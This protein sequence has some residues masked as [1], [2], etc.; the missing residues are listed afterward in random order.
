MGDK[1]MKG[2]KQ[3][4][5]KARVSKHGEVFTDD[6]EVKAMLDMVDGDVRR[7]GSTVLEPTCGTGNFLTEILNRKIDTV[8]QY[9]SHNYQ[10]FQIQLSRAVSSIYGIDIQKDNVN[11]SIERMMKIVE[12]RYQHVFKVS[13]PYTLEKHIRFILH[14]NIQCGNT[15]DFKT[16]GGKPL[17]ISEWNFRDNGQIVRK[18]VAYKDLID[19]IEDNYL[20]TYRYD[21]FK[22]SLP[23]VNETNQAIL[24]W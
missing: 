23:I 24:E 21:W 1:Q 9:F 13:L 7:I 8:E 4:K 22:K 11:E 12:C 6:R 18:D 2:S 14:K 10:E 5:S 3:I 19:G 16:Q 20:K 17:T 15:L